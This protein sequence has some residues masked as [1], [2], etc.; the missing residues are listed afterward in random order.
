MITGVPNGAVSTSDGSSNKV[1]FSEA[2]PRKC[3]QVMHVGELPAT[4]RS[5]AIR[6]ES[7]ELSICDYLQARFKL[8][9]L[10]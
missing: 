2:T 9:D 1:A 10:L 4:V 6:P 3:R 8:T 5:P 7:L